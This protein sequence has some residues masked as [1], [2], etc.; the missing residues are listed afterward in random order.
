MT[1]TAGVAN[2]LATTALACE[3]VIVETAVLPLGTTA[4]GTLED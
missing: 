4:L 1:D 3:G 2:A